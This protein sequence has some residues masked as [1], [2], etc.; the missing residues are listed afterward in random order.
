MLRLT[1]MV[2][3]I[4]IVVTG[5]ALA[6]VLMG[7]HA[8]EQQYR[9]VAAEQLSQEQLWKSYRDQ[10][11]AMRLH[12]LQ[13]RRIEG[14]ALLKKAAAGWK[15]LHGQEMEDSPDKRQLREE[16]TA[17]LA[18]PDLIVQQPPIALP[19]DQA[20]IAVDAAQ[21]LLATSDA[22]G[23]IVV[24]RMAD[25]SELLRLAIEGKSPNQ[26]IITG[27]EWR[28]VTDKAAGHSWLCAWFKNGE[29]AMWA[30]PEAKLCFRWCPGTPMMGGGPSPGR[31]SADGRYLA[32][33]V[34]DRSPL[35]IY[36]LN[37]SKFLTHTLPDGRVAFALRPK[38]AEIA[39]VNKSEVKL[40]DLASGEV[41]NSWPVPGEIHTLTWSADGKRLAGMA[42]NGEVR[43][44]SMESST[45]WSLGGHTGLCR[46][47]KFS[48]DARTLMS[49]DENST[50]WW[51][52]ERG[53]LLLTSRTGSGLSYSGEGKTISYFTNSGELGQWE[54][55]PSS[56][57][58]A[59]VVPGVKDS[60]LNHYD[61]SPDGKWLATLIPWGAMVWSTEHP[62][63]SYPWFL[64][65]L[66]AFVFS[67]E[68][69]LLTVED[70]KLAKKK[71]TIRADGTP[72]LEAMP[73]AVTGLPEGALVKQMT[74]SQNGRT[75]L[76]ELSGNRHGIYDLQSERPFVPLEVRANMSYEKAPATTTGGGR[77]TLSADGRYAGFAYGMGSAASVFDA[78][79]GKLLWSAETA[80]GIALFSPDNQRFL[81]SHDESPRSIQVGTWKENPAASGARLST[82]SGA[83]A[84]SADGMLLATD[85]TRSAVQLCRGEDF[86]PLAVLTPAAP[87]NIKTCRLS[88]DGSYLAVACAGNEFQLWNLT[89]L[90]TELAT[91]GLDWKNSATAP[92][93]T[94]T[95]AATAAQPPYG[96][97]FWLC[98]AALA[99]G[100]ATVLI[101]RRHH[102]LMRD[103]A[104]AEIQLTLQRRD[105]E[106]A[107]TSLLHSQKMKAL[108][109]LAAGMAHDFNNLLSVIRMSNKLISRE[110]VG[111]TEVTEL[112]ESVESAVLQGKQVVSS[113]LSY[114]REETG[115]VRPL[116]VVVRDTVD[117]LSTEFLSGITL[118]LDL[119]EA[120]PNV[121][122]PSGRIEQILL[123]LIVNASDA[124][125]GSG[126]LEIAVRP[127]SGAGIALCLLPP[128]AA[129]LYAELSVTDSGPGISPTVAER[130]FEPFFTT[131]NVGNDRGTGLGLSMVYT[132]AERDGMGIALRSVPGQGAT[133]SI[134]IPVH[135]EPVHETPT[136][137]GT[138][139]N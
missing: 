42:W 58:Q 28:P 7:V 37:M 132:I 50:R 75:V 45:T 57:E 13:G 70:G 80:A 27:L 121:E 62:E 95:V 139:V 76:L 110:T 63:R 93:P 106:Q 44:W 119:D 126:T 29:V 82:G 136:D 137:S 12:G 131:K 61:L 60:E 81:L 40:F 105:L 135:H 64:P 127:A 38:A 77:F 71:L 118:E 103:F 91:L 69:N 4:L 85:A 41:K 124:M 16:A 31:F 66:S 107:N 90:R 36:D 97:A 34:G 10:A 43:I 84:F 125:G 39:L 6:A 65:A 128:K 17:L 73:L 19:A 15:A 129:S 100:I 117:L 30:L 55:S 54:V 11:P 123:N 96:F 52:V 92:S 109:T 24:R 99:A 108:G 87:R 47:L 23:H 78:L 53:S 89:G 113:M 35:R 115:P 9:A 111:N 86:S 59:I 25:G 21:G 26:S 1:I 49:S 46:A 112:V 22:S 114:S 51:D 33:F 32:F 116:A 20:L 74:L 8:R 48:P 120:T 72:I 79:N 122:V 130:I 102:G 138:A 94:P 83:M 101:M 67:P 104:D 2:G 68:G 18:L 98:A 133:F 88:Q 56:V 134:Y 3:V 5:L 14:M